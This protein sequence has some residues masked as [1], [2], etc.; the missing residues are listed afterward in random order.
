MRDKIVSVRLSPTEKNLL[1]KGAKRAGCNASDY[2]RTALR[3]IFLG[4]T[5]VP[6]S[7]PAADGLREAQ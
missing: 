1:V 4:V 2:V 5:T 7:G 3:C 6:K